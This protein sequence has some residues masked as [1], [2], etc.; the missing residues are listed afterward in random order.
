MGPH[1]GGVADRVYV[2]FVGKRRIIPQSMDENA[3]LRGIEISFR[4]SENPAPLK[5][6][7]GPPLC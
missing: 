7:P 6:P 3:S 5:K 1:I 4:L 2:S